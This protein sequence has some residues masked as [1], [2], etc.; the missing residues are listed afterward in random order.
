MS[1]QKTGSTR[2]DFLLKTIT[3]APAMAIGSAGLGSLA[4]VA[5]AVAKEA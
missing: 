3:L 2:R 1:E 4:A 5:P